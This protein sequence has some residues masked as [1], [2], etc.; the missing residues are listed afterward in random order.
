MM[1]QELSRSELKLVNLELNRIIP[2][3]RSTGHP[4]SVHYAEMYQGIADKLTKV[5]ESDSKRI[6][7]T[8]K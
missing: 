3:L 1:T 8:G 6:R 7:I 2:E 5:I 4:L